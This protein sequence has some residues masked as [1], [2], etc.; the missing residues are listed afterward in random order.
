MTL[1]IDVGGTFIRY[2]IENKTYKVKNTG[3]LEIIK[4]LIKTYNIT[5]IKM[6]FAGQVKDNIIYSAPNIN[7]DILDLQNIFKIP[8]FVENDLNC[9]VLAEKEYFQTDD[10]IAIYI[11]TG[12]GCGIVKNNQLIDGFTEIGH[13]PFKKSK[14][15]CGCGKDNCVELFSSGSAIKKFGY[16]TFEE[17]PQNLKELFLEGVMVATANL[18]TILNPKILVFG[19]GV[20]E[21]NPLMINY[22]KD[23]IAKYAFNL[24]LKKLL[25]TQTKLTNGAL[26]GTKYIKER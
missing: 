15:I 17:L 26:Q 2:M 19:G 22:I 14:F 21:N 23:N 8:V 9:A 5:K 16:T 24:S 7:T 20:I 18:I 13:I 1:Y 12:M 10:I 25:I 6:S 11:G 4:N 3:F